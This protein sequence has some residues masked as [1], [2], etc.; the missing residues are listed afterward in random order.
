MAKR[1]PGRPLPE[2]SVGVGLHSG[3]AIVGNIGS[4]KRLEFTSI[5]DTVN[6]ASR[7]EGLSKPLGWTIVASRAAV[8]EAGPGVILGGR[9]VQQ[10]KGRHE[11][12][13]VVEIIGL[14][15]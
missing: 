9:Q 7:L 13:E 3:E 11:A 5:G 14:E 15:G 10:V 12:V 6:T 1:F 8:D 2:F 4:P